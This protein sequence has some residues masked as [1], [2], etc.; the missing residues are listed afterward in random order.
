V[1]LTAVQ[2]L[3]VG[4][5]APEAPQLPS[6]SF[7][8]EVAVGYD[9]S[10]P[11]V[12]EKEA[13]PGLQDP[14][15]KGN[16]TSLAGLVATSVTFSTPGAAQVAMLETAVL[17]NL[18]ASR[19]QVAVALQ[20]NSEH[21]VKA[22]VQ[23]WAVNGSAPLQLL[24]GG[25]SI[26]AE[27]TW[28]P[29][30]SGVRKASLMLPFT[31]LLGEGRN[32]V[33]GFACEGY[34]GELRAVLASAIHAT[35]SAPSAT[36]VKRAPEMP[37]FR[38]LT[39]PKVLFYEDLASDWYG[40]ARLE[41]EVGPDFDDG[42][43]V[44]T[45]PAS[46]QAS[47][48]VLTPEWE[49][50][51][52]MEPVKMLW[53]PCGSTAANLCLPQKLS[54]TIDRRRM[55]PQV[56]LRAAIALHPIHG[57]A[58]PPGTSTTA[59]LHVV[60]A[61]NGTCPAGTSVIE[62]APGHAVSQAQPDN[63]PPVELPASHLLS[64]LSVST[65]PP[66]SE[67]N[68]S[69]A[70]LSP[71][72]EPRQFSYGLQ[73]THSVEVVYLS[74][75]SALQPVLSACGVRPVEL[76]SSTSAWKPALEEEEEERSNGQQ[77]APDGDQGPS[78]LLASQGETSQVD[79]ETEPQSTGE[80]GNGHRR[81]RALL[82]DSE[83]RGSGGRLNASATGTGNKTTLLAWQHTWRLPLSIG[84]NI[85]Y[86]SAGNSSEG[87]EAAPVY[88]IAITRLA[89][90]SHA[91]LAAIHIGVGLD[92]LTLC[93][94]PLA[95]I[96]RL[97]HQ[98]GDG[99][100]QSLPAGTYSYSTATAD[101]VDA[102]TGP[103]TPGSTMDVFVPAGQRQL[104]LRAELAAPEVL[105]VR[106]EIGQQVLEALPD[107]TTGQ[108]V[109]PTAYLILGNATLVA[110]EVVVLAEDQVTSSR[111][112]LRVHRMLPDIVLDALAV[113]TS[114]GGEAPPEEEGELPRGAAAGEVPPEL[115]R[116]LA[117]AGCEPCAAGTYADHTNAQRC[118]LCS[119][120]TFSPGMVSLCSM[121]R[122]GTFSPTWGTTLCQHCN[123]G[124]FSGRLGASACQL[125]AP[126]MTTLGSGSDSC[127]TPFN[128]T[129]LSR[130]YAVVVQLEVA[131]V[132]NT[133][134]LAHVAS[135]AH[136]NDTAKAVVMYLMRLDTA[137]VF[138]ISLGD[139]VV[140]LN[141][142]NM[143]LESLASF[144]LPPAAPA[145]TPQPTQ[146]ELHQEWELQKGSGSR[147]DSLASY[148]GRQDGGAAGNSSRGQGLSKA[149]QREGGDQEG[150]GEGEEVLLVGDGGF[151]PRGRGDR[152]DLVVD[153]ED[154]ERG[155]EARLLDL[156][157]A[158][159]ELWMELLGNDT[160]ST[161]TRRILTA[162]VT[163]MLVANVNLQQDG[164]ED[165]SAKLDVQQLSAD[166]GI[167]LLS[168]S[169]NAFFTRTTKALNSQPLVARDKMQLAVH[170]PSPQWMSLPAWAW[171]LIAA[172]AL[173]LGVSAAVPSCR[174]RMARY[175][176]CPVRL[177]FE[178]PTGSLPSQTF[179]R[180]TEDIGPS[181]SS[182]AAVQHHTEMVASARG[183]AAARYRAAIPMGA[184]TAVAGSSGGGVSSRQL[185]RIGLLLGLASKE[186]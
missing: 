33:S 7:P 86:A 63:A 74:A 81:R 186:G 95:G 23:L 176:R 119:P 71:G 131:F 100:E 49:H 34:P 70:E 166:N 37:A 4:C 73:V 65:T 178:W 120:G 29:G 97:K 78:Q 6:G 133:S 13:V 8:L 77:P 171:V 3:Q 125:C 156:P 42:H 69:S 111:Y 27:V 5:V 12:V 20:G 53:W 35:V 51:V 79:S 17:L 50:L 175:A 179:T 85:F 182:T 145:A 55:T 177:R 104:L 139:V 107:P 87:T 121:C 154:P 25:P 92:S 116:E 99:W 123:T 30:A 41:V 114:G 132:V 141:V 91:R 15:P 135:R 9:L 10:G 113:S 54:L 168:E 26:Q 28:E 48:V 138:N 128:V 18:D 136:V 109:L 76:L 16:D 155:E 165:I 60:G 170:K 67:A 19:L 174:R 151:P 83:G 173:A 181:T 43:P 143:T 142:L 106:V 102:I 38:V 185:S 80:N 134:D 147:G 66:S 22:V 164:A 44:I 161:H 108:A 94:D 98:G 149:S 148:G 163:A 144:V 117:A 52:T 146:R 167:S 45:A 96:D 150:E 93:S 64:G 82:S 127:D 61:S 72:F 68:A 172:A 59:V 126:G 56:Y 158:L 160:D 1:Q 153:A 162:N 115:P 24:P 124:T 184:A 101:L 157:P 137:G 180:M 159:K 31:S 130:N 152:E 118:S 129:D 105:G 39:A 110:T 122:P 36:L 47:L 140:D 40:R 183:A 2:P 62:A 84:E 75:T 46:L 90:A 32:N 169:P 89:N 21:A 57:A 88:T 14:L 103:C 112:T 11:L 58:V